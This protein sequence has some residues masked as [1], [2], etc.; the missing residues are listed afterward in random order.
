[1][2]MKK[3]LMILAVSAWAISGMAQ[4]TNE[5]VPH[6][7]KEVRPEQMEKKRA[8]YQQRRLQL[9]ERE[10]KRIG[11]TK[12]EKAQIKGLQKTHKEKMASNA[13][14]IA[15]TREKLSKL[16]DD[17]ASMD[18][19]EIAIQEV[20]TAQTEQLRILVSN[21]IEMERI[22]GKEK[23]AQFMKNARTQ[24]KKHGRRGGH[25][26]PPRPGQP[27]VPGQG[28]GHRQRGAELPPPES[29]LPFEI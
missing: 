7:K 19:L 22:L 17:G 24:F 26:L 14:R 9:M 4:N 20:S 29:G 21:R 8:E 16:L 28:G 18:L 13:Q 15:M 27:P 5:F 6:Q 2:Q 1:M 12:D 10:L 11:V 3:K 23:Y 25:S